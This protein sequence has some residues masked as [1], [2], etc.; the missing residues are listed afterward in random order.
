MVLVLVLVVVGTG[1]FMM[2]VIYTCLWYC[3]GCC[4]WSVSSAEPQGFINEHAEWGGLTSLLL[5]AKCRGGGRGVA[6]VP[7]KLSMVAEVGELHQP[8]MSFFSR[9]AYITRFADCGGG[10]NVTW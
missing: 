1:F 4:A 3:C 2:A 6:E 10:R 9:F 5:F 8:T 7:S